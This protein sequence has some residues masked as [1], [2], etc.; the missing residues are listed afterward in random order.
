MENVPGPWAV[1]QERPHYYSIR[2]DYAHNRGCDQNIVRDIRRKSNAVI[3]AAAP[4][5]LKV[6]KTLVHQLEN[7][8]VSDME[9]GDAVDISGVGQARSLIENIQAQWLA[10]IAIFV[11]LTATIHAHAQAGTFQTFTTSWN[12]VPRI[13]S[14]Y[15]PPI[16]QSPPAVVIALHG[17]TQAAQN[18]PPLTVCT[19]SMA[20]DQLADANGF[21]V[22][23]PIATWK[24]IAAQGSFF[25][26]SYG[27]DTY[28]PQGAPDDSGF[29]RSLILMQLAQGADPTRIFVMG[30]SSGGM[31]THRAAIDNADLIAAAAPLSGTAWIGNSAPALPMPAR[32]VSIL[33]MH[34]DQDPTIGYCGGT[35]YGWGQGRINVPSVDFDL[36][37]W[38]AADGFSGNPPALCAGQIPTAVYSPDFKGAAEIQFV[39]EI[40]FGHTYKQATIAAVWEFFNTHSR[41]QQ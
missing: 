14:V 9:S 4:E 29:I 23:C 24:P 38:T 16:L 25:W 26:Q 8:C 33:E 3:M 36:A 10:K 34:G 18:N 7:T 13:Y 32:P 6:L 19:K 17:T 35:F 15:T 22:V 5:L 20:W 30:F 11:I 1:Y 31:M 27:T 39:R 2:T 40:G 21:I 41:P 12:G 28:F 37:Y